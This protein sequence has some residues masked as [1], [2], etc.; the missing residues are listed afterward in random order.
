MALVIWNCLT[1]YPDSHMNG[2]IL[3]Y[4]CYTT[5]LTLFQINVHINTI[6]FMSICN[7]C[8][9]N[10]DITSVRVSIHPSET[11]WPV[12]TWTK[13]QSKLAQHEQSIKSSLPNRQPI[14]IQ[15]ISMERLQNIERRI[16]VAYN[17]VHGFD[18]T[19][20]LAFKYVVPSCRQTV[21][22]YWTGDIAMGHHCA[23]Q[24]QDYN[25]DF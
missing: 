12:P 25:S 18:T 14:E 4:Y 5:C 7:H 20:S 16:L 8:V 21:V 17:V 24:Q 1:S 10:L 11:D 2:K 23:L 13:H 19:S 6:L 15:N 3:I 22:K 9:L